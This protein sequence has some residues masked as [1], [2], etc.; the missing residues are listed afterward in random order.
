MII[1]EILDCGQLWLALTP[2]TV[3]QHLVSLG[4]GLIPGHVLKT[5]WQ[6]NA[7]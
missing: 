3:M 2:P 6:I 4:P 7:Q 5:N 1:K